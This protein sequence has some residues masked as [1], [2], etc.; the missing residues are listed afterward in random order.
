MSITV[1]EVSVPKTFVAVNCWS[2]WKLGTGF[3]KRN[4]DADSHFSFK[5]V[6]E[7]PL[8]PCSA[9]L[10]LPGTKFH[11][12]EL[13]FAKVFAILFATKT[14]WCFVDLIQPNVTIL[15]VQN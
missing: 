14:F 2:P 8:V 7:S 1:F 15:S 5:S 3:Y 12:S 13:E 10:I 4:F 6:K 11:C 9:G